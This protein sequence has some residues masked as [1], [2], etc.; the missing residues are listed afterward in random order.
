MMRDS[1]F[2]LQI[3]LISATFDEIGI[4]DTLKR[5]KILLF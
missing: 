3:F 1:N 2:E 5:E 4:Q